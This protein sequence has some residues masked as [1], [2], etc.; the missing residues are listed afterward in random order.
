MWLCQDRENLQMSVQSVLFPSCLQTDAGVWCYCLQSHP[1]WMISS[2]KWALPLFPPTLCYFHGQWR[3]FSCR[4]LMLISCSPREEAEL[5]WQLGL[6]FR[7]ATDPWEWL[8]KALLKCRL[9]FSKYRAAPTERQGSEVFEE[10]TMPIEQG[11]VIQ[12][13]VHPQM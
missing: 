2:L 12:L 5:V 11:E 7:T 10:G 9:L 4:S 13:L 3:H 1:V 6:G 8:Q